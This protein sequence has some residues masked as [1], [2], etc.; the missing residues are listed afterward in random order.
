M[1]KYLANTNESIQNNRKIKWKDFLKMYLVL[2]ILF[3]IM[4]TM[5]ATVTIL[6]VLLP[7]IVPDITS[8]FIMT[9]SRL[10]VI[11]TIYNMTAAFFSLFVGPVTERFGYKIILYS[12]MFIFSIGTAISSFT[13]QF[14]VMGLAQG[15]AGLG[16]SFF[17][18]ATIA[19][20]GEY[21]PK[22]R[23]STAIGIIMSSFY[24][25]TI[26]IVPINSYIA[27]LF[28]WRWAVGIMSIIGGTIAVLI[29][30]IIPK[31]KAAKYEIST[32]Q[33]E[34]QR[35]DKDLSYI[36]RINVVLKNKF[37]IGTFFI[38]L[39]QRGGL[40]AM[41]QI[42]STWLYNEFN[43]PTNKSGLVLM[44]SGIAALISNSLFS[45]LADKKQGKRAIIILGTLLTGVW[46]GIFPLFSTT[47]ELAV[48]GF[49]LL[50][51]FGGISMGSYNAF[52]AEVMPKSRGTA[53]SINNAFGQVSQALAVAI[54]VRVIYEKTTSYFYC[55]LTS[56]GLFL[57]SVILMLIFIKPQ[58]IEK[59]SSNN[60][61]IGNNISI[62]KNL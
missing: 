25:A 35:A 10:A 21:F 3:L 57:V 42:L 4:F 15:I 18:P 40:F 7:D 38:T 20:A 22:E 46:I 29:I 49:I 31:F 12:G 54:I 58:E 33:I 16:A 34:S 41:T 55:G 53:V 24:V 45:W 50:N 48:F 37:A 14:W 36:Q 11:F 28:S 1:K 6:G 59:Q 60:A 39:F 17:G 5:R 56:M 51:F 9:E 52:V 13:T 27:A 23:I 43:L 30:F 2:A 47:L 8:N 44:G 61:Q 32:R 26:I 19:F 62:K